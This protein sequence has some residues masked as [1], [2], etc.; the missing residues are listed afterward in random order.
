MAPVRSGSSHLKAAHGATRV[1]LPSATRAEAKSDGF[2][3]GGATHCSGRA[4]ASGRVVDW[5][6]ESTL[7]QGSHRGIRRRDLRYPFVLVKPWAWRR[8]FVLCARE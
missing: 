7:K 6:A 1:P 5:I 8:G 2:Q 3:D 4:A